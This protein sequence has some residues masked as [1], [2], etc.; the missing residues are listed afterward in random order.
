MKKLNVDCRSMISGSRFVDLKLALL[1][2]RYPGVEYLS[3]S[4]MTLWLRHL[5]G[6]RAF[7]FSF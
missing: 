2:Y 5:G 6:K 7:P 3:L 4:V 1:Y